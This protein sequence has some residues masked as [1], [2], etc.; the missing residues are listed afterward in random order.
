[1]FGKNQFNQNTFFL[2]IILLIAII[3]RLFTYTQVFEPD[4]VVFLETDPYYHMW[5]VFSYIDTFPK[6]F[7]FDTYINY[8]YGALIGWPPLFDQMTA[9]ISIILGLGKPG[10]HLVE[11]VGAFMPMVLGI[12]SIIAVFFIAKEIFDERVALFASLVLAVLPGHVQI[13]ILGFTDHHIAEVLLSVIAYLFFIRSLHN[14]YKWSAILSGIVIGLSFMTWQGAPIFAGILLSYVVIQFIYDRRSN[15]MSNYLIFSGIVAFLTALFVILIFYIW[16]PWQQ[17]ITAGILSYFQP[18]YL[19]I[20]AI[21][22]VL[23]GFF[24]RLMKE[25]KWHYYPVLMIAL[26]ISIIFIINIFVPTLYQSLSD[27][28]GYLLRD[29]PVLK[30]IN[31]AQPLFFSFD[32]TFLGWQFFNNPAWHAFTFSFY[33]AIIGFLWLIYSFRKDIDRG[34][35]FFVVWT[36]IV[37]FLALFQRRFSY[38]LSINIGILSGFFADE[39]VEKGRSF[40]HKSKK[41]SIPIYALIVLFLIMPNI[42]MS[43]ELSKY[44][45]GPSDDWY[46]SLVWLRDN[47]PEINNEMQYG[48]MTWWDYG[49]WI[50]YIS[51]RPVVANNFQIGGD[52]AARFY[53]AQDEA[54]AN[55][56][57]EKRKARYVIVDQRMGLNKFMQGDQLILKGTFM[58]IASFAD[59]DFAIYLDKNNLP[60]RNYFNSM[61]S[62]LHIFDGNG[63]E[64]YRMIYES[65]EIHY[66]LFDKPT[67][68]IKI[69]EYVK[70][71][72]ITGKAVSN[73]TVRISGKIITNQGRI[74]EYMQEAKAD[75]N[76]DFEFTVPYSVDSPYETRLMNKYEIIYGNEKVSIDVSENDIM[77]GNVIKVK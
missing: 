24:S 22:I 54:I 45:P 21:M 46:D 62:R 34:K 32:G 56:I 75:D 76:G 18:I 52:E 33:F 30:Q 73:E 16:T 59:T 5:R 37:L 19:L 60:N 25:Q 39:I 50:L 61:Y 42:I 29:A 15:E 43:Y 71:A 6:T 27:G 77:D 1:M 51:K 2:I 53:L 65:N 17:T 47:T 4:R 13:S 28:I 11:S 64:N 67:K 63:L 58:V 26:F 57:M 40:L 44:P 3:I 48:I 36:L 55:K 9:F 72:K 41:I 49:N 69:F 8:P 10:V 12:L 7:F 35:L 20:S 66:N 14:G 38:M 70:G 74:F 68:N 31:E 23:L